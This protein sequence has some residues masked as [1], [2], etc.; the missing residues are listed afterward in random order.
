MLEPQ[1]LLVVLQ[2]NK[3]SNSCVLWTVIKICIM[4]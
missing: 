2:I 4:E 1:L 3:M